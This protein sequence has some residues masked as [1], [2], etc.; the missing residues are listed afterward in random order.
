MELADEK[1]GERVTEE[2]NRDFELRVSNEGIWG[3]SYE[4]VEYWVRE[5]FC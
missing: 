5:K 1:F 3:F 4:F 2:L